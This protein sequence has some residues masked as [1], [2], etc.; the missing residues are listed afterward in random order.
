MVYFCLPINTLMKKLSILA[1]LLLVL[2]CNKKS[3]EETRVKNAPLDYTTPAVF[4]TL[5]YGDYA[6]YNRTIGFIAKGFAALGERD[7]T[8]QTTNFKRQVEN[9][10]KWEQARVAW[11]VQSLPDSLF[12]EPLQLPNGN[13]FGDAHD[14]LVNYLFHQ[15]GFSFNP[16]DWNSNKLEGF[17]IDNVCRATYVRI[18]N[19]DD[20]TLAEKNRPLLVIPDVWVQYN[21]RGS[22]PMTGFYYDETDE[23]IKEFTF[24]TEDEYEDQTQWYIWHI[25]TEVCTVPSSLSGG[26]G[27][28]KCTGD[29]APICGDNYCDEECGEVYP[30]CMDCHP[31]KNKVLRIK[32]IKV[33]RDDKR[34]ANSN[35]RWRE[36]W[37][38]GEYEMAYSAIV[39]HANDKTDWVSQDRFWNRVKR[40]DIHHC[41]RRI[42]FGNVTCDS[43]NDVWIDNLERYEYHTKL[44]GGIGKEPRECILS[45]NFNPRTD[46]IFLLF[47]EEDYDTHKSTEVYTN[48]SGTKTVPINVGTLSYLSGN[49]GWGMPFGTKDHFTPSHQEGDGVGGWNHIVQVTPFEWKNWQLDTIVPPSMLYHFNGN[50]W[51][52][53]YGL[54]FELEFYNR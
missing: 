17:I 40:S 49:D 4:V 45:R 5:N 23:M 34:I 32:A 35:E 26:T 24:N 21:V 47:Y 9:L 41:K 2:S 42:L 20:L 19:L 51:G 13:D 38:D 54:E 52:I 15:G 18:P 11:L 16:F 10:T 22:F 7:S 31:D 29:Y 25:D 44:T 46:Y 33:L 3:D 43:D 14:F 1:F 53:N 36:S 6:A 50:N 48:K 27:K 12:Q 39:V 28:G 37:W 8:I 30:P